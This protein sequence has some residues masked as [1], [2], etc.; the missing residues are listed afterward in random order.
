MKKMP[1]TRNA[2]QSQKFLSRQKA[3]FETVIDNLH[4]PVAGG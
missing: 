2:S 1:L 3:I 4:I